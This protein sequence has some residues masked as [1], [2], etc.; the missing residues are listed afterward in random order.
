MPDM[1][2]EELSQKFYAL[3]QR[4]SLPLINILNSNEGK[5]GQHLS[6]KE[7]IFWM[8]RLTVLFRYLSV[9]ELGDAPHP[10]L[11]SVQ[12]I[13]P[14]LLRAC[15]QYEESLKVAEHCCRTIRFVI[16]CLGMQSLPFISPLVNKMF[17]VYQKHPHS[18]FLYLGSVLVDEYGE[19]ESFVPGLVQML[20]AFVD[21]A[22]KIL[23][24]TNGLQNCS[25]T[26]DDLFRLALRFVQKAPVAFFL[27]EKHRPLVACATTCIT[28]DHR[29]ACQSVSKFVVEVLAFVCEMKKK[30]SQIQSAKNAEQVVN[31][32]GPS[33][34]QNVIF[35]S[36]FQLS[37][38]LH[39]EMA[40]ILMS[41]KLLSPE[42]LSQWLGA[43]LKALPRQGTL[44]ASTEQLEQVHR[45]IM[46]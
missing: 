25:D 32:Y 41:V 36:V 9:T 6:P 39:R 5:A 35:G 15:Q 30:S 1:P 8:D 14:V 26:V 16:R 24:Q 33:L 46:R 34:V 28:L 20:E 4:Q 12:E 10:C 7:P 22:F 31:D 13:W 2:R 45:E 23:Q 42:C 21:P 18:C 19:H 17:E 37:L 11:K 38:P 43:A 44:T 27:S 40:E 29:D 3:S